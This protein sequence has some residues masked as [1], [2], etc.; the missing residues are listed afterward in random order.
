M[1]S[2]LS[3]KCMN[4]FC[5]KFVRKKTCRSIKIQHYQKIHQKLIHRWLFML[6]C[7]KEYEIFWYSWKLT[8]FAFKFNRWKTNHLH[9]FNVILF[10][11]FRFFSVH[12]IVSVHCF[13]KLP[14]YAVHSSHRF[15][16]LIL[17]ILFQ[18]FLFFL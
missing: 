14:L 7:Q 5:T 12:V 18:F 2:T 6:K 8:F 4:I 16:H 3:M 1:W 13:L 11:E 10:T 17:I 9:E 15:F